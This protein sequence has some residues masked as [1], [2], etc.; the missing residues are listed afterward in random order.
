[1]ILMKAIVYTKYGAPEVLEIK[2]IEKPEPV[3]D[4]ILIRIHAVEATKADCEL[5]SFNFAV[6][7]FWLPL[8]VAM[9]MSKPKKQVLGGYFAGEVETVGKDVSKF[10]RGDQV[11]GTTRLLFGAYGEYVCLPAN[12][13][14]V[15]KPH[16][17]S[18]EEAAAAPLG[19]LNALHFM[20]KANIRN[21][22]KILINGAGGSIGTFA[23]QIAKAMGAEVTAVDST[24][25]EEMLRRIGADHFIDYTEE[26]FTKSSQTYDVIFNMVARSSYTNC[27]NSLNPKGRYLMGNPRISDMLRSVVTSKFT[28]KTAIFAFAG[29]KEEEL[30]ELKEMVE[31]GKIKSIV[32]KIYPPE[33]AA[34]AHHIVET[35]QRLGIVVI[36]MDKS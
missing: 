9:G 4:E 21:G 17:M 2:E 14:I 13:T 3:D 10:K 5:R 31:A 35:E 19:G 12:Y 7:W 36:S 18:F 25:K 11:F 20:K 34:E 28:N 33:Q 23:V 24:I 27:V 6:K 30:L 29:E 8:R 26:D 16:N 15:P 1:M 32:D 22:E